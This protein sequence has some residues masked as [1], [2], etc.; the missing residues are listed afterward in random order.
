MFQVSN[1]FFI[2]IFLGE[3]DSFYCAKCS[4]ACCSICVSANH[5]TCFQVLPL[6]QAVENKVQLGQVYTSIIGLQK[7]NLKHLKCLVSSKLQ[8]NCANH[9]RLCHE[10]LSIRPMVEKILAEDEKKL[11]D[12][13]KAKTMKITTE[14]NQMQTTCQKSID[15]LHAKEDVLKSA[16]AMNT[17]K[18]LEFLNMWDDISEFM[19]KNSSQHLDIKTQLGNVH[20]SYVS[21]EKSNLISSVLKATGSSI[22]SLVPKRV[23]IKSSTS[24]LEET[25]SSSSH[26]NHAPVF[27][28]LTL[29]SSRNLKLDFEHQPLLTG[30]CLLPD[31]VVVMTDFTNNKLKMFDQQRQLKYCILPTSPYGLTYKQDTD[32]IIV[33]LPNS[34]ELAYVSS[35]LKIEKQVK[36][37]KE[38]SAVLFDKHER[39]LV[40][41]STSPGCID[42][43]YDDVI[44]RTLGLASDRR[45]LFA[46]P[47]YLALYS[48]Q[49]ILV[50]DWD[51][52]ALF[53]IDSKGFVI[54]T[55]T[56][57]LGINEL[58][59]PLGITIDPNGFIYL[60][61]K[62]A[63]RIL[64]FS[65]DFKFESIALTQND[66]IKHPIAMV[67]D[68]RG[69]LYVTENSGY[70]K[71]F[72]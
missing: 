41:T 66:H 53:C 26:E 6:Q 42:I 51:K 3:Y 49:N 7:D 54:S 25:C 19:K 50:S 10:I 43:L 29:K 13:L 1:Q 71:L 38:Y 27:S 60:A 57:D 15:V 8:E 72:A 9:E 14:L 45:T 46:Q 21:F 70:L 39:T 48:K 65:A 18:R 23:S 61:D 62:E 56:G 35:T 17:V 63:S 24:V 69:H 2:F 33:T 16:L 52:K 31:D 59:C 47:E 20:T 40:C 28:R 64:R 30:I 44:I 36:V 4:V 67:F 37:L 5:L 68:S 12:E 58:Q 32:H 22:G 34:K 11:L 55:F